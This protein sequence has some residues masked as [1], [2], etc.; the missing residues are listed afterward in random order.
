MHS[1]FLRADW[2]SFLTRNLELSGFIDTDMHDGSSLV[3]ASVGYNLS[4]RWSAGAQVT[5]YL[6]SRISDFGSLPQTSSTLF[7]ATRYF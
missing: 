5:A 3:Q 1:A 7:E 2:P 6:G 4:D